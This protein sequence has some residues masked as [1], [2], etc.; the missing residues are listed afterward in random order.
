MLG[1]RRSWQPACEDVDSSSAKPQGARDHDSNRARPPGKQIAHDISIA[2]AAVK[3]HCSRVMQKMKA[4][5]LPEPGRMAKKLTLV[6]V[7]PQRF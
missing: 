4:G 7:T 2:E 1:A 3:E 6:P 5:S